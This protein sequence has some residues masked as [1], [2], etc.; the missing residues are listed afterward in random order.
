M[1]GS[2]FILFL[3]FFGLGLLITF[4]LI[5]SAIDNSRT[6]EEISEIRRLLQI[7]VMEKTA[8]KRGEENPDGAEAEE[9][10]ELLE[11]EN[12]DIPYDTCP[13][14]GAKISPEDAKYP[15]CEIAL[16]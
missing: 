6:S 12:G 11:Y 16:K 1:D 5:K 2:G 3:F 7:L 13:A 14:C 10:G 9:A 15:S 4:L 8:D